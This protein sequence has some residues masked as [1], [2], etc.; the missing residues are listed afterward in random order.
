MISAK[1][2]QKIVTGLPVRLVA[3]GLRCAVFLENPAADATRLDSGR[4]RPSG[5]VTSQP[6]ALS[7][8]DGDADAFDNQICLPLLTV[9][10]AEGVSR[11]PRAPV[12]C[13]HSEARRLPNERGCGVPLRA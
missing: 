7:R 8:R 4:T 3:E 12:F 9:R 2:T 10:T 13:R 1:M 6:L 11:Q 5:Q